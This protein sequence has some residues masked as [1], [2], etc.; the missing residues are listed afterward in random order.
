MRK[1]PCPHCGQDWIKKYRTKD[2]KSTFFMC[3]ECE[4]LWL[5]EE[6]LEEGT[7]LYLSEYMT[8]YDAPSAWD[9]IEEIG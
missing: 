1:I 6:D 2:L 4:S 3:P 5:H 8:Q 7:E 9:N